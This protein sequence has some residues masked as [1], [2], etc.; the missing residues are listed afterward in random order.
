M[1]PPAERWFR[2]AATLLVAAFVVGWAYA[3]GESV[4]TAGPAPL[5]HGRLAADPLSAT[6]TPDARFLLEAATRR[7]A[8]GEPY[9][10]ESGKLSIIIAPPGEPLPAPDSL[11]P[12]GARVGFAPAGGSAA[13]AD[14]LPAGARPSSAGIWTLLV[15]LGDAARAVPDL[16]VVTE[17]PAS[18]KQ[19]GRIGD[20]LLGEWPWEHGG[21]PR[22]PAYAPPRGF[23][24]VT[25]QNEDMRI[26]EHIRLR[27]FLTKGQAAVW[28]KYIALSPRIL[29]KLELTLQELGR[30]G[31]PVSNLGFISGFRTP[32]YNENGGN[33][34]G[35]A[36]LSRHMYGDAADVYIDNDHDGRMDDLN[37]DGR[38]D[39][40]DAR[41][42]ARAAD[43]VEREHPDLVGGIG[44][45]APTGAHWGFVHIDARGYHARWGPW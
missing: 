38:I 35:R 14:T 6:T 24:R 13:P 45:Y 11:L 5:L 31:H 9:R 18:E 26:S 27:D 15:R 43:R 37:G 41:V 23:I 28:P 33:T 30:E 25:P 39:V 16:H 20:Y 19:A 7:L 2:A 34:E 4:A 3:I 32:S 1:T 21:T 36:S 12:P 44:V 10:G 8:A 42:L 22:T 40:K 29:D 17:V